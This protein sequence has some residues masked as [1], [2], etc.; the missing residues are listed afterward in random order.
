MKWPVAVVGALLLLALILPGAM[1]ATITLTTGQ[2]DYF[3]PAGQRVEIPVSVMSTFPDDVPGTVRFSTDTQLQKTGTVM[4][5]T[6]NRVFTHAAPAGRSFLNLTLSPSPVSRD[7][8]VHVSY[9]YTSP[10]PVN[11][12]LPEFYLHIVTD[13]GLVKNIPAPLTGTSVPETGKIPSESSV[14]M[15]EQAVSVREQIGSDSSKGQSVT[16]GQSPSGTDAER[17]QQQRDREE[18]ERDQAEL[19]N[20]LARDPLVIAVNA[21]LAAEGFSRQSVDTQP[22]ASD[23]GTFSMLYRRRAE[24]R[25]IVQGT[26]AAGAVPYVHELANVPITAD[27]ALDAN[28]TYQSFARILAGQEYSHKESSVNRTL[29]GAVVNITYAMASGNKAYVNA[30]TEE[31]RVIQLSLEQE[32]G[33]SGFP[34]VP[35]LIVA[36]AV[37][38]VSGWYVY[39][40][41]RQ[42]G[43]RTTDAGKASLPAAFDHRAEAERILEEAGVAYT[44]QDYA[45]AYG[46]TGRALRVFLSYEYGDNGEVTSGEIIILLRKAGRDTAEIESML[47]QC[48]DVAFAR[49]IPDA[50]EFTPMRDR[51]RE[52]IRA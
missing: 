8:K 42:N 10:S 27:S 46:L 31:K 44:R 51:V 18:R 15:V 4:I 49:G 25:V 28:V 50:G 24:D 3:F 39:R 9:Y 19:D 20:R 23:T 32:P 41:Y 40:R 6:E 22:A 1:A 52:I 12:S 26:M 35:V 17:E 21:S 30:T 13:P 7:Y 47:G 34:L 37:L 43:N 33:P 2:T 48:S 11:A 14:S 36:G 45:H 16:G 29:T 5:S 38:A